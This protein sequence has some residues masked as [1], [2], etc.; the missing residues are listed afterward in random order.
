VLGAN[1]GLLSTAGLLI[2][3]AAADVSRSVLIATGL[4]AVLA[5][6]GSM[7]VGEYSSVSSQ[8]DAEEADLAKERLE[9]AT[10]PRSELAELTTIYERRGLSPGLASEVAT[11]LMAHDAL[12][13]HARDELGLDPQELARPVQAAVVSALSFAAG[14]LL[15]LLMVVLMVRGFRIPA[16]VLI[17]LIGLGVLGAVGAQ[18]G[19]APKGRAALRVLI[20]GAVAMAV[21][22]TVGHAVGVHL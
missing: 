22:W 20:G 21:T 8:R 5:G 6:A 13:S 12:G 9:L 1:D 7:A 18:L 17:T 19:G 3:V 15:P 16:T 10:S 2:G 14:A 11:E 4:A